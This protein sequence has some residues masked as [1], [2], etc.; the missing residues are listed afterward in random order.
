[1][2]TIP[3]SSVALL[4]QNKNLVVS[5]DGAEGLGPV[6]GLV[7]NLDRK[8]LG[9]L[10]VRQA[11]SLALDR[12]KIIDVMFF[13]QGTPA[14]NPIVK[15]N[16]IFYDKTLKDYPFDPAAAK[17]LLDEAG[18]PVKADGHRFNHRL[19]RAALRLLLGAA[20][21]ICPAGAGQCR[22]RR[23]APK[24]GHGLVAE[25]RLHRLGLRPRL[26]LHARLRRPLD[27]DGSGVR[28]RPRFR[29]VARSTTT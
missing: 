6:A 3:A 22:H 9:D 28:N 2:N 14:T 25:A 5:H 23:Q 18:Y 11:I 21:R 15:A 16:P 26:D 24:P 19:R 4:A 1:M 7:V 8:P 10:K 27:C 12:K 29:R 13:G 17:K 20:R